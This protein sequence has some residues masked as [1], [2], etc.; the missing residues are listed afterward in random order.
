MGDSERKKRHST[1]V[2]AVKALQRE[3]VE[4][5]M[6]LAAT[7]ALAESFSTAR[8]LQ[9][10]GFVG[11]IHLGVI[12]D[13]ID[14]PS[15]ELGAG[16]AADFLI[17]HHLPELLEAVALDAAKWASEATVQRPNKPTAARTFFIRHI[18]QFFH[19]SH[20][21]PLR[22]PTLAITELFFDCENMTPADIARIAPVR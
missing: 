11:S 19:Q 13:G 16:V 8:A 21:E 14:T 3:L 12:G 6:H 1:I 5:Q 15:F 9:D 10:S 20:G 17:S 7:A 18:T 2:R 4:T 22:S